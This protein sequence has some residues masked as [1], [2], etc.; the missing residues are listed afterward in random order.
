MRHL[1]LASCCLFLLNLGTLFGIG[2]A[3]AAPFAYIPNQGSD[4]V[5][6]IDTAANVVVAVV[7]VGSNPIGV[8]AN[9]AGTIVYVANVGASTVSVIDTFSNTV[10]A[11]VPVGSNPLGIAVNPAGTFVYV[12]NIDGGTVSVIDAAS[13]AVVVTIPVGAHPAGVAFNPAGTFAYVANT[14][15]TVSVIDAATNTVSAAI[16]VGS[17]PVGVAFNPAGTFAYVA[18][19]GDNS[20]SVI[21]TAARAV[22][23]TVPVGV[24]PIGVAFNPAGTFAY[25]ANDVSD[26]V[27]VI[28]TAT[29]TVV[30]TV[31]VGTT[32]YGVAV[33]PAGTLVYVANVNSDNVSV[34][35]AATN[36]VVATVAT[37]GSPAAL[38]NFMAWPPGTGA[39]SSNHTALWWNPAESGWGINFDHQGNI[40]FATLFTYDLSGNPMWLV[41]SSGNLQADGKTYAGSLYR[42]TGPAF[43][44]VPFT[45]LT[46]PNLTTVGTMSVTF[47][48]SNTATLTYSVNGAAVTKSIQKQVYEWTCPVCGSSATIEPGHA[49]ELPG[50]LVESQRERMGDEHHPPGQHP[51]R[52]PVHLRC[53]GQGTLAR[54]VGRHETVGRHF[55]GG[56]LPD[57]RPRLQRAA[58]H[59]DRTRQPDE[60]RNHVAL[61]LGRP[62]RHAHLFGERPERRE[63]DHAAGVLEPDGVLP[64]GERVGSDWL[65]DADRVDRER[66]VWR[67]G[68]ESN[69]R[70]RLCRPLH[71]HSATPPART[72]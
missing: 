4:D 20:V 27:S 15:G 19:G 50:P 26:S 60:G 24:S 31:T 33:N 68:S 5:S 25:V 35:D 72:S 10:L 51:V 18:N 37:G 43:N 58:V 69:R 11:T 29:R 62:D 42:T 17:N 41:M 28:D 6:V 13:N 54:D 65:V 61:V 14:I 46:A 40:I 8:A 63:G 70:T 2:A 48:T 71:N 39:L 49:H 36:R 56:S 44:A 1:R 23:A 32:P 16:A 47:P 59:A 22:V 34:I 3:F 9:S 38:G 7:R 66:E 53:H 55:P 21:D 12:T 45:P 57:D 67:R 52:D 30:A 64:V